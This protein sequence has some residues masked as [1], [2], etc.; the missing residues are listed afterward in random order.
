MSDCVLEA[1]QF[2]APCSDTTPV[3]PDGCRDLIY[4]YPVQGP[5]V[6][7]ISTLAH[8]TEY[9]PVK[10][11]DMF[12]G[13]RLRPGSQ[14][15]ASALL[16]KVCNLDPCNNDIQSQISNFTT[17]PRIISAILECF[18]SNPGNLSNAAKD[19]GMSVRNLQR[20]TLK[21]TFRTPGY[22]LRMA[23]VRRAGREI[24][25]AASLADIAADFGYS[26]QSHMNREIKYWLGTTPNGLR[27]TPAYAEQLYATGYA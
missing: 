8:Q 1:W 12:V 27:S 14:I 13:F 2:E 4:K 10:K 6:W 20:I 11:G 15:D 23:R 17:S 9:I 24:L 3:I 26:D 22:W 21:E 16:E 7:F 5:P 18:A 25:E 19:L